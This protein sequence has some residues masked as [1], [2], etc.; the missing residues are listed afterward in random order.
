MA[1][2]LLNNPIA[3]AIGAIALNSYSFFPQAQAAA[4]VSQADAKDQSHGHQ[5]MEIIEVTARKKVESIQNVPMSV[6]AISPGRIKDL[7]INDLQDL[8]VYVPGLEQPKLAIQSRLVLRGVSSGDNSAFEQ[9]VGTYVDGIYRGRMHQQRAGFF[10]MERVEV[11]KGPQVTLY[12]N[13]SVGGAISMFSKKPDLT[14]GEN[15]GFLNT[16]YEFEYQQTQL[17]GAVNLPVS[18]D[19]ALRLSAKWRQQNQGVSVNDFDGSQGARPDDGAFR[20]SALWQPNQQLS[21]NFRYEQGRYQLKGHNLDPLKQVDGQGNAW[22]PQSFSGLNDGRLNVGNTT[23]FEHNNTYWRTDINEGLV[24]V[25]Y[26]FDG[27][28]L[29]SLSGFSEY[30]YEQS[31]D[32]DI[33]PLTVINVLQFET[34]EQFSQEFRLEGQAGAKMDYLL[35]F[36]FQRN[37]SRNDYFVDFNMSQLLTNI[38]A[39]PLSITEQ[40]INPFSRDIKLIQEVEQWALFGHVNYQLTDK[41]T[42][43]LGY[44]YVDLEKQAQQL[45]QTADMSHQVGLGELVDARWLSPA[46]TGLLINNPDYVANPTEYIVTLADGTEIAPVLVPNHALGFSVVTA[47]GG[48]L[49]DFDDLNRQESHSMVQAS[50]KYQLEDKFMLYANFANGAKAGGFDFLY[51]GGSLDEVEYADESAAVFELGF[52]KDWQDVRLNLAAFYGKYDN[53]QVSVFNGSVG[54]NVGNAASSVSRGFDGELVVTLSDDLSVFSNFEYLDFSYDEFKTAS[55]SASE[56]L[57]TG[58]T[59]CDWSGRQAPFVPKVK[60]VVALEY[61]AQISDNELRQLLSV[62]YKGSH[63]TSSDN[64]SQTKQ[65]AYTL[66]DYHAE[67]ALGQSNW[68][69]GLTVKNLLDKDYNTYTSVIPLAPGGSFAHGLQ[70]GR[71]IFVEANFQ[72]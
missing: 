59:L 8:S 43:S 4:D 23:P 72:F 58:K 66:V 42:A 47:G 19:F 52:K 15:S 36:Y 10:D 18:D 48:V 30:D 17:E 51:E 71:E 39:I 25:R 34:Y 60:A 69:L 50:V 49:H 65:S 67:L 64:E 28:T 37:D 45:V 20:I 57:N 3:L 1:R 62:N 56:R 5:A 54:F 7:G 12:G 44:R 35:G 31:M 21:V 22:Q 26:Q 40:L 41:L 9:S 14:S 32:V 24:E 68:S 29:V 13:S 16:K 33:T 46:L 2:L 6:V 38:T 11:L 27:L 53:L 61:Y 63:T 55:C 70:K